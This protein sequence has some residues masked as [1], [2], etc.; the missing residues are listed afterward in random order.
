MSGEP[1]GIQQRKSAW[2]VAVCMVVVCA[3]VAFVHW[4]ALNCAALSFDDGEYLI[5]NRLVQNPGW[6]SS[7]RFLSEVRAPS[8]VHGYYQ[9]LNMISIM[10]DYAMGGRDD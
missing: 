3:L 5:G 8:T 1:V 2:D 9:P 7:W 4:P 6:Q 10:L